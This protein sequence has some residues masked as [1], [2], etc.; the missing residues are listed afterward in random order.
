MIANFAIVD[1]VIILVVVVSTLISLK[2]GF[3]K[4][5]FSL[6]TWILALAV[7]FIFADS[8]AV[9]LNGISE[10]ASIKKLAAMVILFVATLLAGGII[11]LLI[12]QL[13]SITGLSG[14]DR[15]LGMVFGALRGL[16]LIVIISMIG[17]KILPLEE[18]KWWQA[19]TLVPQLTKLENWTAEKAVQIKAWVLPLLDKSQ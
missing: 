19:S 7:S 15:L 1:W 13:I 8:L 18:E 12:S 2:R 9:Y 14:T 10:S 3:F 16:L 11:R 5:A 6:V 17:K 4:E